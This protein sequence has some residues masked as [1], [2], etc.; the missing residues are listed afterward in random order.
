MGQQQ[1]LLIVLGVIIVGIA[2][3]VG[4]SMFK[5]SAVDANRSAIST[6]LSNLAAK[7]QRYYRTPVELGGGG[8]SFANFALSPLDTGNANGSYRVEILTGDQ[9][10]VIHALG[11]E[12]L[13]YG[14]FV[15]A[16]DC[17]DADKS[18]IYQGTATSIQTDDDTKGY[19]K[20]PDFQPQ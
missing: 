9:K 10:I 19:G 18:R 17:V 20:L 7:A 11:K 16:V 3:A 6:D 14:R 12:K 13:P 1:L 4:I 2:I 8:N 5:S 15:A